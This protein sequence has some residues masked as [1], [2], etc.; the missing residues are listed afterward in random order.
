MQTS[1]GVSLAITLACRGNTAVAEIL[2]TPLLRS[3]E[4]VKLDP[5]L[6]TE[7]GYRYH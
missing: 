2:Q 6:K 4:K 7:T 1:L 3:F 5:G